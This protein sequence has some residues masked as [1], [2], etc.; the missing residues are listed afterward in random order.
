MSQL[1]Q[2][3]ERRV[4]Q[5]HQQRQGDRQWHGQ[6]RPQQP[7]MPPPPKP[8]RVIRPSCKIDLQPAID[9]FGRLV[10]LGAWGGS[11]P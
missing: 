9:W 5:Q 6:H 7:P 4:E 11:P 8:M 2:Q 10:C 3:H 1:F